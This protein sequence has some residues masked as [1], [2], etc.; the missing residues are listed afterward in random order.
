MKQ[1]LE[2]EMTRKGRDEK[3]VVSDHSGIELESLLGEITS[4]LDV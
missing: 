1:N 3:T 2:I 4:T